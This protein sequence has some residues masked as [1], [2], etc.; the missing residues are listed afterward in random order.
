[1]LDRARA[2]SGYPAAVLAW[3]DLE[4]TGLDPERDVV[5]E[6]AVLVTDDHLRD[7]VEGPDLVISQPPSALAHM[8][9]VVRDMHTE[10]GLIQRVEASNVSLEQA[11][12][13][14]MAFL[15]EHIAAPRTVP[16]CGNSI[17]TDR[18]FLARHLREIDEFL[19]YRCYRRVHD[20]G[21][22]PAL[23]S[24]G[25]RERSREGQV[26]SC[27]RRHPRERRRAAM[28]STSRLHQRR[29]DSGHP[30][31]TH[32]SRSRRQARLETADA[33]RGISCRDRSTDGPRAAGNK[34][35][36]ASA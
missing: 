10:S 18:R 26:A 5:L 17:G 13:A 16:L 34:D 28:V 22:G 30:M 24:I 1:M 6:I 36:T 11:G 2:S 33:A 12:E 19:H 4:M 32:R 9:D 15:R 14:V 35:S 29:H 31:S 8:E 7:V 23:A 25:V 3:M 27:A 20:Q 21:T